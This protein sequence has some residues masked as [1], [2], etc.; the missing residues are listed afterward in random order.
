MV[1]SDLIPDLTRRLIWG[2]IRRVTIG[3]GFGSRLRAAREKRGMTIIMLAASTGI[4]PKTLQR[5][6][7]GETTGKVDA[8]AIVADAL[9]VSLD[10]LAGLTD[11][12]PA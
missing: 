9:G 12:A 2:L 7:E 8:A 11:E 1:T 5:W 3:Q 6:E 4:S 10:D